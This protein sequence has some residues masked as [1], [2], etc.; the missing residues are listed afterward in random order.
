[1]WTNTLS[2]LMEKTSTP[3]FLYFGYSSATAE[4][5]VAQTKVKSPG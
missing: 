5:S 1:L 2:T 3:S 4:I